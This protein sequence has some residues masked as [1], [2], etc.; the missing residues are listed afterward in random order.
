MKKSKNQNDKW[1]SFQYIK[2]V[3]FLSQYLYCQVYLQLNSNLLCFAMLINH[4]PN[5]VTLFLRMQD[6]TC[7]FCDICH[8]WFRSRRRVEGSTSRHNI[9]VKSF[10]NVHF[11]FNINLTKSLKVF[12]IL[13]HLHQK[14]QNCCCCKEFCL[15]KHS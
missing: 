9:G 12:S 15:W 6:L 14:E 13:F 10:L 2:I 11:H 7:Q 5:W 3:H 1:P 4:P 8:K